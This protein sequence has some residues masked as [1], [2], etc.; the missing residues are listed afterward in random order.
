MSP[1]LLS[2]AKREKST[3]VRDIAPQWR[4]RTNTKSIRLSL[5]RTPDLQGKIGEVI[6]L[7][8]DRTS[9]QRRSRW[10]SSKSKR[11]KAF[12]IL[13]DNGLS[14]D[15]FSTALKHVAE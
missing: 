2:L 6:E 13:D 3:I 5:R 8:D 10:Q 14:S 15:D 7:P 11:F 1:L 12:L 9:M 4:A